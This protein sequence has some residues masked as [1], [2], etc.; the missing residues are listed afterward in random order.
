MMESSRVSGNRWRTRRQLREQRRRLETEIADYTTEAD[1]LE[2]E[3]ILE[4]HPDEQTLEIRRM[5]SV[6]AMSVH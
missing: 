3:A 4:P 5:L 2:L 6:H 1:R